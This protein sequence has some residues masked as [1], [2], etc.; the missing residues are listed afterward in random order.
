M[1]K[2]KGSLLVTL[3]IVGSLACGCMMKV[4]TEPVTWSKKQKGEFAKMVAKE[5][6]EYQKQQEEAKEQ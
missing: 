4:N 3:M 6:V 5:V 1:N 2:I